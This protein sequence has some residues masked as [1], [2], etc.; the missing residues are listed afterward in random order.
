MHYSTTYHLHILTVTCRVI[1]SPFLDDFKARAGN[2]GC[3]K[4]V[5]SWMS[6]ALND[7]VLV[8]H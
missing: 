4:P 3:F 2:S 1:F 6:V 7:F 5:A 8:V